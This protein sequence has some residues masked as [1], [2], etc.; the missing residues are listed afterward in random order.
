MFESA[1]GLKSDLLSLRVPSPTMWGLKLPIL[2]GSYDD[3]VI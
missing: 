3:N 1:P 2:V